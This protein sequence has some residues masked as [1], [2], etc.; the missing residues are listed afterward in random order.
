MMCT[1]EQTLSEEVAASD[2]VVVGELTT[3]RK[4]VSGTQVNVEADFKVLQTIYAAPGAKKKA[5]QHV[6][7]GF[8]CDSA[9]MPAH[10]SGYPSVATYCNDAGLPKTMPPQLSVLTLKTDT[11]VATLVKR[12]VWSRCSDLAALKKSRPHVAGVV[13]KIQSTEKSLRG[14]TTMKD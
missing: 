2:L 9:P 1:E 13:A 14:A 6:T 3:I 10:L 5:A 4:S 8:T 11:P 7:V 12:S